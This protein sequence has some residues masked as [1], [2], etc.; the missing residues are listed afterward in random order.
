MSAYN[1][2]VCN[3]KYCYSECASKAFIPQTTEEY[4][5]VKWSFFSRKKQCQELKQIGIYPRTLLQRQYGPN[6]YAK[7][8]RS[9]LGSYF[10]HK[11]PLLI[12]K[13]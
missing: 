10:R 5:S 7:N 3:R 13:L 1:L 2:E 12:Y 8:N 11:I 6:C 4:T 9:L